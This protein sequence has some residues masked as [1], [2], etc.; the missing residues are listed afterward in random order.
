MGFEAVQSLKATLKKGT[1][2]GGFQKVDSQD[3][4]R[5]YINVLAVEVVH[6]TLL[7]KYGKPTVRMQCQ[8]ISW[9]LF[10]NFLFLNWAFHQGP[11]EWQPTLRESNSTICKM[12]GRKKSRIK[13]E[14]STS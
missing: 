4:G 8:D 12:K 13:C 7:G 9:R 10:L 2:N 6:I 5:S 1:P 11:P 14:I 3:R